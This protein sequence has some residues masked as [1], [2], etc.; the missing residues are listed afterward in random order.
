MCLE[1]EKNYFKNENVSS[2]NKKRLTKLVL[3]LEIV[4]SQQKK[5]YEQISRV[6]LEINRIMDKFHEPDLSVLRNS[7]FVPVFID[8]IKISHIIPKFE[9]NDFIM[10]LDSH[11]NILQR[12]CVISENRRFM[13]L[14]NKVTA[15]MELLS[16]SWSHSIASFSCLHYIP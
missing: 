5:D 7:R 4:V 6:F 2:E 14:T 8:L 11:L 13:L 16:W 1:F 15:L 12:F 3:D 9:L 10:I